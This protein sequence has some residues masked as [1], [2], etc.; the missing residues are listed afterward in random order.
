MFRITAL[1]CEEFKSVCDKELVNKY[2]TIRVYPAFPAP[3]Q[4]YDEDTVDFEKVK[5]LAARFVGSRVVEVTQNNYDTSIND[6][7]G[8]PKVL[9]F[10]DKKGTPLI[11]KALSS[12]FD[13]TLIFGLIRDS[14][15]GIVSKYK[16]K[17]FPAVFLIKEKDGKP[18]K[19][20]GTE[21]SYQA[22]FDFINIYSETFVFRTNNEEAVVS[23][24]SKP[25][26]NDHIPL[27]T[28]DSA[29]DIC[30]K[31]EG[32]L[33]VIFVGKDAA[34]IK[35]FDKELSELHST[36]QQFASKISRGINFYFMSLDSSAEAKF[37]Q[38]FD[39][40]AEELPKVVILNPGK[41]KRYLVHSGSIN[42]AEVGKT[43]D[44][45][46]GGD[47]KFINVKGNQLA[48]LVSKYPVD[49]AQTK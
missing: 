44:R 2:P 3:T 32:A 6:N 38:M 4:D 24:A 14:E 39:L 9:L 48:D 34:S 1:D 11:F 35:T 28:S 18:Q 21:Y 20:E 42:E 31:K 33:C 15:Q 13:K 10:S 19:Y 41:R 8:K 30:L 29:D 5:K 43:L 16:V 49:Q 27:I 12:H 7:P 22:I 47:A 25:W 37:F 46:L 17:N 40:K 26:L 36:G 23:A 45:I